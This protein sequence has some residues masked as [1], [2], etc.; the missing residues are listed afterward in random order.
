MSSQIVDPK[1]VVVVWPIPSL[2]P[3]NKL[4]FETVIACCEKKNLSVYTPLDLVG[5]KL[6]DK[7]L[8]RQVSQAILKS[9]FFLNTWD[10]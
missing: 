6:E 1:N 2:N 9:D 3:K 7:D 10:V 8:F 4:L 5:M